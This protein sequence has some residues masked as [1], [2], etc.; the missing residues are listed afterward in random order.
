MSK[1]SMEVST[2]TTNISADKN[3]LW[4]ELLKDNNKITNEIINSGNN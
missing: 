2:P 3:G 1:I 4:F